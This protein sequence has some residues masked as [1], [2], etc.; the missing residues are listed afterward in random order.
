MHKLNDSD[1]FLIC[2]DCAR[3]L[4]SRVSIGLTVQGLGNCDIC[5]APRKLR[6][7]QSCWSLATG[8]D[9]EQWE[10]HARRQWWKR[11]AEVHKEGFLG[12][13]FSMFDE[14]ELFVDRRYFCMAIPVRSASCA[15]D[16]IGL[17]SE[18]QPI[19]PGY[20]DAYEWKMRY[21]AR[22]FASTTD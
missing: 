16:S 11:M 15:I 6:P 2:L 13:L 18:V 22:K 19:P 8:Y 12:R 17:P 1:H 5:N 4:S 3:Y 7:L 14:P 20:M 21:E 10:R 9:P